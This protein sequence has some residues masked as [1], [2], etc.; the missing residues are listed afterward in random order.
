MKAEINAWF[1]ENKTAPADQ[2]ELMRLCRQWAK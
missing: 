1:K 2:K